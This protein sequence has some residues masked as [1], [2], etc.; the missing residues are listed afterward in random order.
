MDC[1]ICQRIGTIKSGQNKFFVKEFKSGYVVLG[2]HQYYKGYTLLLSKIHTDEL[3][4][5]KPTDRSQFLEDMA[6]VSEAVY[7]A[8]HPKKLNYELLGNTDSHLHWHIVPRYANDPKPDVP[9]WVIPYSVR[10]SVETIPSNEEIKVLKNKLLKEV[11]KLI[12]S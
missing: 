12:V 9:I 6:V 3:H 5:L 2:D 1:L 8:F 10:N 11:N 7:K 4:K